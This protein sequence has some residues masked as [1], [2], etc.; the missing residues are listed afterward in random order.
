MLVIKPL[1]AIEILLIIARF[2][3]RFVRLNNEGICSTSRFRGFRAIFPLLFVDHY[4]WLLWTTLL[5]FDGSYWWEFLIFMLLLL[6]ILLV[7]NL[8]RR[9]LIIIR[10]ASFLLRVCIGSR[11]RWSLLTLWRNCNQLLFVFNIISSS[12]CLCIKIDATL[13]MGW[14]FLLSFE[15]RLFLDRRGRIVALMVGHADLGQL[16]LVDW[17]C[18]SGLLV[19]VCC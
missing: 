7:L 19:G 6:I 13:M 17:G 11:C 8:L 1:K 16:L 9:L 4:S 15:L 2:E 12:F 18:G 14:W 5:D 10:R 3:R